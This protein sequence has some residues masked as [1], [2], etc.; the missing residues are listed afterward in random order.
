MGQEIASGYVIASHH[1]VANAVLGANVRKIRGTIESR[2]TAGF[3][4]NALL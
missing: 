3:W 2:V 1:R 4:R